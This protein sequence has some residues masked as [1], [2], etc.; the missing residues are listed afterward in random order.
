MS[1]NDPTVEDITE[2]VPES[3]RISP[4]ATPPAPAA[5]AEGRESAPTAAATAAMPSGNEKIREGGATEAY[6]RAAND[7][8]LPALFMDQMPDAQH[9]DM[10]A[11]DTM[12]GELSPLERAENA[13]VRHAHL[14]P[15]TVTMNLCHFLYATP[16]SY[17]A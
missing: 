7:R 2:S 1:A 17:S 6:P 10:A 11:M 14:H 16:S 8:E 3:L 4:N 9:P 15:P 12:M 13:R 5:A